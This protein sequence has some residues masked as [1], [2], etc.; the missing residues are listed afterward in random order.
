MAI[1]QQVE[2]SD[3]VESG[4]PFGIGRDFVDRAEQNT[5]MVDDPAGER[6]VAHPVRQDARTIRAVGS[7]EHPVDPGRG[8]RAE[9]R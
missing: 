4:E 1:R 6:A 5:W 9:R 3:V 2:P 7:A 8:R